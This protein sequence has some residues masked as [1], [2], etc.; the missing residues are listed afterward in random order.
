MLKRPKPWSILD[1]HLHSLESLLH[2]DRS[3]PT[4][5]HVHDRVRGQEKLRQS[6]NGLLKAI[7]QCNSVLF[8]DKLHFQSNI[9]LLLWSIQRLDRDILSTNGNTI[10]SRSALGYAIN[11]VD[12]YLACLQ[13]VQPP[14][15][16]GGSRRLHAR[17]LIGL[18]LRLIS[19]LKPLSKC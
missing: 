1:V 19:C 16:H 15:N 11:F 18:L 8:C 14:I 9:L 13:N 4:H 5:H 10:H 12:F 6:K 17:K 2:S 3:R 7:L